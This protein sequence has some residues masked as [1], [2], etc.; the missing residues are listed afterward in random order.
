MWRAPA[1]IQSQLQEDG[2]VQN[3]V[4]MELLNEGPDEDAQQEDFE[5]FQNRTFS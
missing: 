2:I 4:E 5:D 1:Q 3:V